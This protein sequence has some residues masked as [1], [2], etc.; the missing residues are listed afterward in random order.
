MKKRPPEWL[1]NVAYGS[2]VIPVWLYPV[3][4]GGVP[5]MV[6]CGIYVGLFIWC[7]ESWLQANPTEKEK[8]ES[9]VRQWMRDKDG[10]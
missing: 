5:A 6:V 1:M 3:S 10:F 2:M 9:R 8:E 4:K 7:A